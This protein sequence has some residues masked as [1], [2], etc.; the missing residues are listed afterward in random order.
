MVCILDSSEVEPKQNS[1]LN[2][3]LAPFWQYKITIK[4]RKANPQKE[5]EFARTDSGGE[6]TFQPKLP[7]V[8]P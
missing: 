6:V 7:V 1:N 5:S 8:N 4:V 3:F 2:F